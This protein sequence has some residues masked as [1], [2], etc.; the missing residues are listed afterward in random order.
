MLKVLGVKKL[1][2]TNS[3]TSKFAYFAYENEINIE[4][5]LVNIVLVK[6]NV[7]LTTFQ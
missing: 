3:F 4:N 2:V 1:T 6:S 7:N 5:A